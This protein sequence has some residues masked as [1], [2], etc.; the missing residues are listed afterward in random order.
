MTSKLYLYFSVVDSKTWALTGYPRL[1]SSII[2][3]L[4]YFSRRRYPLSS[5]FPRSYAFPSN[6]YTIASLWITGSYMSR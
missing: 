4:L 6:R 1:S 2:F 3:L 5:R